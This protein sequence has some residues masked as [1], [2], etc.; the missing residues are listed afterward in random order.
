MPRTS[1]TLRLVMLT[2]STSLA[3][4]AVLLPT[5]AFAAPA[6][7]RTI[8]LQADRGGNDHEDRQDEDWNQG[9]DRNEDEGGSREEGSGASEESSTEQGG[10]Q[11]GDSGAQEEGSTEG[12]DASEPEDSESGVV[13]E[14]YCSDPKALPGLC[15][16]GKPLPKGDGTVKIPQ[17]T[18][19]CLGIDTP[20]QC[21]DRQR[22]TVPI[23]TG[24]STV[25]LAV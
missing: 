23:P 2:A 10:S 13:Q 1:R 21:A 22:P 16:D 19:L 5:G 11:E 6:A 4:G 18:K 24:S 12:Q 20:G 7:P 17:G 8:T 9:E 3:A 25:E 14:S 15:V